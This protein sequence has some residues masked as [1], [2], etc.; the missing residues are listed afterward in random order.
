MGSAHFVC[1]SHT[2]LTGIKDAEF[3]RLGI[4]IQDGL[5]ISLIFLTA[6]V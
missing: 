4:G 5:E 6:T 3:V 2:A 1:D